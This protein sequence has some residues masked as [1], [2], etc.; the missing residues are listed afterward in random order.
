MQ[1]TPTNR[2]IVFFD[3]DGTITS[4]D[5][6]LEI[7]KFIKGKLRF[8]VGLLFLSPILIAFKLKLLP[9]YEAKQ[10]FLSYFLKGIDK[11]TF[12]EQCRYFATH[13]IPKLVREKALQKIQMHLAKRHE[14]V[15]V[16]ASPEN[17][18]SLWCQQYNITCIATKLETKNG[19]ITGRFLGKNCHGKEKVVRILKSFNLDGYTHILAYGD[20]TGDQEMLDLA[21]ES[22]YKPFR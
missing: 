7:I 22:F 12:E 17:W 18:V 20:S 10:I 11:E 9:N 16:S 19:K 6:L 13:L 5:T 14:V 15:V 3:F 4:Q 21:S 2:T 8:Y 1:N